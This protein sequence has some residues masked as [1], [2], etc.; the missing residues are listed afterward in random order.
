MTMCC[1][2]WIVGME[3]IYDRHIASTMNSLYH[4]IG[5]GIRARG[6]NTYSVLCWCLVGQPSNKVVTL[7]VTC[8]YIIIYIMPNRMHAH[9][10]FLNSLGSRGGGDSETD[11]EGR[12]HECWGH[13]GR[14]VRCRLC[15][16]QIRGILQRRR[17]R[18]NERWVCRWHHTS[19]ERFI[20]Y[21][22]LKVISISSYD[23]S[24][25]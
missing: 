19:F 16:P 2:L 22:Y 14:Y 25:G 3:D 13:D 18:Y 11:K 6:Y 9:H 7:F 8:A 23:K 1:R 21:D 24:Y 20:A 15:F 5:C 4:H 17:I 12:R 10:F